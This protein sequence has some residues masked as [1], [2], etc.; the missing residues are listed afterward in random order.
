RP[1]S[2]GAGRGARGVVVT[3]ASPCWFSWLPSAAW[4]PA[5]GGCRFAVSSRPTAHTHWQTVS[6]PGGLHAYS[7]VQRICGV[8]AS[9]PGSHSRS[10]HLRKAPGYAFW[11][12]VGQ[13]ETHTSYRPA[14]TPCFPA[15][16][17]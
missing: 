1:Q 9:T 4:Q 8:F 5:R 15:Q 10:C 14:E 2:G 11:P 7:S 6:I 13:A 17:C 16:A 3:A 12:L